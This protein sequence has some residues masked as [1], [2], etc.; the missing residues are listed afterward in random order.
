MGEYDLTALHLAALYGHIAIVHALLSS[1]ANPNMQDAWGYVAA[2]TET[3]NYPKYPF[4]AC[5]KTQHCAYIYRV[6]ITGLKKG[7]LS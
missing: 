5:N 4:F 3:V 7:M 2:A 1:G 6:K